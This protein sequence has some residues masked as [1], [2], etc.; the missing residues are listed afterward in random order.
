MSLKILV[1]RFSSIGDIVLTTPVLR[2][3]KTQR[4]DV[5]LHYLTKATYRN[6]LENN[7]YI[8][9]LHLLESSL[10]P[11]IGQLRQQKFDLVID[12]HNNLRTLQIKT[13][14]G[15]QT[16]SFNKLNWEKWL[17]VHLK[18]NVLP[19][20]H[21]VDRYLD[22]VRSLG[23][24]ND[25]RGLDYFIPYRDVVEKEWL[26]ALHQRG[27]VAFAIG[28]QHETKKLPLNRLIE[29]C[30]K[31][32]YPIVLLGG[33]EDAPNGEVI[34]QAVGKGLVFNGCG[35]YNLN[36]SASV[37]QQA[38]VV[39]CHDTGLMH[40]AAAFKKKVYSIWGNT[41]P[42]FGMYPYQT[43]FAILENRQ[44]DCRPCSKIGHLKCPKGHF[45]CMNNLQFDFEIKEIKSSKS[46]TGF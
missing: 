6:M 16:Y 4:P 27:Y 43:P 31:I 38:R 23:I 26:P 36:Q 35:K 18:I 9:H 39:F 15:V 32:D 44:L 3:L 34:E 29:L 1:I 7:P 40:I 42:E 14:L 30:H 20:V 22:T 19:Q 37:V 33:K 45:K 21:I 24:L 25:N 11:L 17:L 28:G 5:E 13:A 2:C 41:I 8:D 12:L 46:N 10:W